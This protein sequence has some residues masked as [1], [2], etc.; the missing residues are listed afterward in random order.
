LTL[1]ATGALTIEVVETSR[2][3]SKGL[4]LRPSLNKTSGKLTT[5]AQ[6]FNE[7]SWGPATRAFIK[8]AKAITP[9]RFME[10]MELTCKYADTQAM[11]GGHRRDPIIDVDS[12]N[13]CASLIDLS[14]E[15]E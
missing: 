1:W 4:A 6:A 2:M 10:I 7:A 11:P 12:N 9:K 13:A 3:T 8:S 5:S 15:D 14:N